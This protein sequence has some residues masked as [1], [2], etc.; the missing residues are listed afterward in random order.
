MPIT[1]E[2]TYPTNFKNS[3]SLISSSPFFWL[4]DFECHGPKLR[5]S[6]PLPPLQF[7]LPPPQK[8]TTNKQQTT[9]KQTTSN[10]QHSPNPT[11]PQKKLKQKETKKNKTPP[12]KKRLPSSQP[13]NHPLPG[14]KLD[15]PFGFKP[16]IGAGENL[17]VGGCG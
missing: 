4:D 12:Q 11:H 14:R 16:E 13:T 1:F 3:T 6:L 7:F 5:S 8:K 10:S 17:N 2:Q 15:Q 9:K